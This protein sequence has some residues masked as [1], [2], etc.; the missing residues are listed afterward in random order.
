MKANPDKCHLICSTDEQISLNVENEVIKNSK[1]RK[2][3]G[4]KFDN[5]LTFK[6]HIDDICKKAGQKLNALSRIT[7]YMG[8]SKKRTLV[9][10]F[11]LSQF[12]YCQLIWMCHN[13]TI[14]NKVNRLHERCLRL[15]YNDRQSSFESLLE[16]DSSVSIHHRNIRALAVEMYKVKNGLS[17]DIFSEIFPIRQQNRFD[18]RENLDFAIPFVKTVNHGF[19]SLRY[20]GPKT[21]ESI[22]SI[23][24]EKD[25]LEK[26]KN[27]IKQWKPNS[28]SC[29]L[30]KRYIQHVG[31]I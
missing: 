3:L 4:I 9:N 22:P 26:F 24:R 19:E 5:K 7:P 13:R 31:Y 11:F 23:I 17:P 18:L 6:T 14:N 15:I 8:F 10:A 16:R 21:W 1:C 30:C 12:N 25:S 28:C 29:R 20:L 2:L 27:E